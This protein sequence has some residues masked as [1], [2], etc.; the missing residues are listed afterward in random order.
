MHTGIITIPKAT[1][2]ETVTCE[3]FYPHGQDVADELLSGWPVTIHQQCGHYLHITTHYGYTGWLD[4]CAVRSIS[5]EEFELWNTSYVNNSTSTIVISRGM[6][7]ILEEPRVQSR[8]LTTLFMGSAV[9]PCGCPVGGWQKVKTSSG[10]L[11]YIP[12]VAFLYLNDKNSSQTELRSA[13]LD[14]AMSFLGTQYRWGGKTREGIDCSGLAFMSY[15]M[16][17]ITI[18]RDAIIKEGYPVHEIP[19]SRIKPADLLYFPGHVAIYL[20]NGKYIHSTGNPKSFGCVINSLNSK[21]C[22]YRED[23]SRNVTAVGSVFENCTED[24]KNK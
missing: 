9:I 4:T 12:S 1:L 6:I 16:C 20:G 3:N 8:I 15:Y 11:G 24:F 22:D 17:G 23:L 21:D 19:L 13:I 14:Y 7:D 18:Y 2:Y 5:H 10:I